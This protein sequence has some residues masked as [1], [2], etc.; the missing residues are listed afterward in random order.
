MAVGRGR[1]TKAQQREK[2]TL[3]FI[4]L[5][6][7]SLEEQL[8]LVKCFPFS[9][10]RLEETSY[11]WVQPTDFSLSEYEQLSHGDPR[12]QLKLQGPSTRAQVLAGNVE[13]TRVGFVQPHEYK[14]FKV[15][16]GIAE[17]SFNIKVNQQKTA[18][19]HVQKSDLKNYLKEDSVCFFLEDTKF[20]IH[21]KLQFCAIKLHCFILGQEVEFGDIE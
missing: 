18:K 12:F 13:K 2:A 6:Q 20:Q 17:G 4:S 11:S 10:R 1:S 5:V 15:K 9:A 16:A 8:Y 3:L 19:Y 21:T 14:L 7:A